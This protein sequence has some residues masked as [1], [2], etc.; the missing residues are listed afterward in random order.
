VRGTA[1]QA[2]AT[3]ALRSLPGVGAARFRVVA[4]GEGWPIIPGRADRIEYHDGLDLAVFTDRPRLFARL[5]AVPG[6]R[7]H[8]TGDT[9]A[10]M[11]FPP[12]ALPEVARIIG[13]RRRRSAGTAQTLAKHAYRATRRAEKAPISTG[14]AS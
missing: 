7:R 11:L 13:A 12:A 2:A 6:V 1:E 10:R 5:L 3:E 14:D 9:E 8:Q 4:D